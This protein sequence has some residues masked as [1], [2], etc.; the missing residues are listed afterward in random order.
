MMVC[1]FVSLLLFFYILFFFSSLFFNISSTE[2]IAMLMYTWWWWH[3]V[4]RQGIDIKVG[5]TW[6]YGGGDGGCGWSVAFFCCFFF[7]FLCSGR[8]R[9][10]GRRERG[11]AT[12][13]RKKGEK[14][15][16]ILRP[17]MKM[18]KIREWN[19]ANKHNII[20]VL[21][22]LLYSLSWLSL[23]QQSRI[24]RKKGKKEDD[25]DNN[26]KGVAAMAML[27]VC[28]WKDI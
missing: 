8:R 3:K 27:L 1:S 7:S 2:N 23:C 18:K 5:L 21:L 26:I 12:H 25:D 16:E 28:W 19:E 10:E 14:P 4:C 20:S 22:P 24:K 6:K 17:S 11:D 13:K 15:A 9:G